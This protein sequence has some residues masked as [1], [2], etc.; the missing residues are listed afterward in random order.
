ML[1]L[2]GVLQPFTELLIPMCIPNFALLTTKITKPYL[3]QNQYPQ[4]Q[5]Y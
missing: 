2:V 3:N 5:W 1:L 4:P